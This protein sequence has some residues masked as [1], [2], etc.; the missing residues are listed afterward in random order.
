MKELIK[1]R[2][3]PCEGNIPSLT[4]EEAN[5]LLTQLDGWERAGSEIKKTF[6]FKELL[7]D[8][9]VCECVGLCFTSRGSPP[10]TVGRL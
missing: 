10:R 7:S 1:K 6:A 2:C 8:D 5:T 4:P 9:G 3:K